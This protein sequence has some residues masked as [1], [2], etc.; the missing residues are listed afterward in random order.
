MVLGQRILR[1]DTW[2]NEYQFNSNFILVG[3]N[4]E[5]KGVGKEEGERKE[6]MREEA[7]EREDKC[8]EEEKNQEK[9]ITKIY[10]YA[11]F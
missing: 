2:K 8:E 11:F 7:K 9:T 1:V 6:G 3:F 5:K 10:P 4:K